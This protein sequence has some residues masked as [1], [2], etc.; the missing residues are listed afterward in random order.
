MKSSFIVIDEFEEALKTAC[1]GDLM[2]M[3]YFEIA[4]QIYKTTFNED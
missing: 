3:K 1:N 4:K 2:T